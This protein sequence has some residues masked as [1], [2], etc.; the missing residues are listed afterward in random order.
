MRQ[1]IKENEGVPGVEELKT[2]GSSRTE[3]LYCTRELA[4]QGRARLVQ[5]C[6]PAFEPHKSYSGRKELTS[7]KLSS[8]YHVHCVTCVP[9]S[10]MLIYAHTN[11]K[12]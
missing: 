8:D 9:A 2:W 4:Q 12:C 7:F 1:F 6:K 10:F 5:A 3:S 11:S